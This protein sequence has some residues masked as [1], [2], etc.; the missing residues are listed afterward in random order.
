M[1][2]AR[3][4]IGPRGASMRTVRSWLFC[5]ARR[6]WLPERTWR[7]Q[8]RKK[9]TLNAASARKPRMPIRNASCGVSRNGPS[10]RGSGGRNLPGRSGT[11]RLANELDLRARLGPQEQPSSEG[12]D[13]ESEEEIEHDARRQRVDEGDAG[14]SRVAKHEMEDERPHCIEDGHDS[15]RE[16]RSVGAIL[17]GRLAVPPD[18]EAGERQQHEVRRPAKDSDRGDDRHLDDHEEEKEQSR[19]RREHHQGIRGRGL[20]LTRTSTTSSEEKSTKGI[21]WMSW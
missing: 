21:T 1:W 16:Q 2:P 19:F 10:T 8:S 20:S 15:D 7:A 12:K 17:T 11:G 18:P 9:R 3:S 14:R 5:A 13:R 4:L 6:N